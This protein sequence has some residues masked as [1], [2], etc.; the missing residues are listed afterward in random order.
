MR[1]RRN[2]WWLFYLLGVLVSKKYIY[3]CY[4]IIEE[5]REGGE[6]EVKKMY[7]IRCDDQKN[8]MIY[9]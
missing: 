8:R 9:E 4:N 5:W 2:G 7:V 1:W 3:I 6:G